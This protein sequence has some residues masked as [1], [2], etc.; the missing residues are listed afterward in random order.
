MTHVAT[1]IFVGRFRSE[2]FLDFIRH[3]AERLS[4]CAAVIAAGPDRFEVFVAGAEELLDAFELACS[5][6]PIDCLV[7]DHYRAVGP[8]ARAAACELRSA[9]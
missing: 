7:L 2:S 6:G 8:A 1:L 9:P 4:L 5:L 3:R